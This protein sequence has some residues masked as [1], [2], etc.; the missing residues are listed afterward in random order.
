MTA[1]ENTQEMD[2]LWRK[3]IHAN[4]QPKQQQKLYYSNL[5]LQLFPNCSTCP[6][7]EYYSSKISHVK[8]HIMLKHTKEKPFKCDTCHKRFKLKS[9]L[10]DHTRIHTGEKPFECEICLKRFKQTSHL[11]VHKKV[12]HKNN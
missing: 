1:E 10:K 12:V 11:S 8:R 7:C 4:T 6:Y 3:M 5:R 2:E 9:H